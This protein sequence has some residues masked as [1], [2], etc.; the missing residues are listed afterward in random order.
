[1]SLICMGY[2]PLA[3]FWLI[4]CSGALVDLLVGSFGISDRSDLK[5]ASAAL[6]IS[7]WWLRVGG[8]VAFSQGAFIMFMLLFGFIS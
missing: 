1:M 3:I 2:H 6:D 5:R 4:F 7:P 8:I